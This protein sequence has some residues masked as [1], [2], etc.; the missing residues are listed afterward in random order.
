MYQISCGRVRF[1][2]LE[3]SRVPLAPL[4]QAY[5]WYSFN[6]IPT[7]GQV[8]FETVARLIANPNPLRKEH[9][10]CAGQ[11]WFHDFDCKSI[12]ERS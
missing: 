12:S 2:C 11:G 9:Q 5:D 7:I 3:F 1:M 6:V 8:T 4:R 10:V